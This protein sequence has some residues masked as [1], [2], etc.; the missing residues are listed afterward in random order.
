MQ[1]NEK[2][3]FYGLTEMEWAKIYDLIL[4]TFER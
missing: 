2:Y 4:L 1:K 3:L